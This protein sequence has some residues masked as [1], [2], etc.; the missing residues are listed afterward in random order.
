MAYL[1]WIWI[2]LRY[3]SLGSKSLFEIIVRAFNPSVGQLIRQRPP[4]PPDK[5]LL[6][7]PHS[8]MLLITVARSIRSSKTN[9]PA[10]NMTA[11]IIF[12]IRAS[13]CAARCSYVV[14]YVDSWFILLKNSP[15]DFLSCCE[16]LRSTSFPYGHRK[17]WAH[18]TTGSTL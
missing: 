3:D 5:P 14:V 11:A 8:V 1:P 17:I 10:G 2:F 7:K 4:P 18:S 6:G 9:S 16:E 13:V 12:V 15:S